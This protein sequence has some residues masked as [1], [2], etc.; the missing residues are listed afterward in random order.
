M[1][2]KASEKGNKTV[3]E[4]YE[5]YNYLEKRKNIIFKGKQIHTIPNKQATSF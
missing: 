2:R 4:V 1:K 3:N 5:N